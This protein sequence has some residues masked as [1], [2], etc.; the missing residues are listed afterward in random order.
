[1]Q[2]ERKRTNRLIQFHT[3]IVVLLIS[4][5]IGGIVGPLYISSS[6]DKKTEKLTN[7]YEED[8]IV[9]S[10]LQNH[11][12]EKKGELIKDIIASLQNGYEYH[13]DFSKYFEGEGLS[14]LSI[15]TKDDGDHIILQGSYKDMVIII[16]DFPNQFLGQYIEIHT[17]EQKNSLVQLAGVIKKVGSETIISGRKEINKKVIE[18]GKE[19]EIIKQ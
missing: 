9:Y 10:L 14:V 13:R 3:G 12:K 15:E 19:T 18:T 1:M 2:K 11:E 8:Q 5:C 6:F 16:N 17:I 4:L 7:Q